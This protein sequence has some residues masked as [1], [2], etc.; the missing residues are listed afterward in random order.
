M[1]DFETNLYVLGGELQKLRLAWTEQWRKSWPELREDASIG[2]AGYSMTKNE[3]QELI[4]GIL[5]D[6]RSQT[7]IQV[8]VPPA[9]ASQCAR[10]ETNTNLI[11][12]IPT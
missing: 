8:N 1:I 11:R 10:G 7:D 9:V 4:G 3:R 2:Q 12:F 5:Q 6:H